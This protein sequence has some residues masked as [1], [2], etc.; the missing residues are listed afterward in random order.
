[1]L[2]IKILDRIE[3]K[4]FREVKIAKPVKCRRCG[5]MST[6]VDIDGLCELCFYVVY[7]PTEEF[8]KC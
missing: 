7:Q 6:S 5:T 8:F 2:D 3:I 1:M 4:D